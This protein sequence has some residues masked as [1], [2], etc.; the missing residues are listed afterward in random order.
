MNHKVEAAPRLLTRKRHKM[1]EIIEMLCHESG[2]SSL[3]KRNELIIRHSCRWSSSK[4]G[5]VGHETGSQA[6]PHGSPNAHVERTA[7]LMDRIHN[8]LLFGLVLEDE[9]AVISRGFFQSPSAR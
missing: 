9:L 2:Q 7:E 4:A 6:T 5:V 1:V 8:I 3:A